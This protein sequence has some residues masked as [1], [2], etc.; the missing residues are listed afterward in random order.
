MPILPGPEW[1]EDS[2]TG[3]ANS[4]KVRARVAATFRSALTEFAP[5]LRC[6]YPGRQGVL[7]TD[8]ETYA[9]FLLLT[10]G[11]FLLRRNRLVRFDLGHMR[12][13]SRYIVT[14]RR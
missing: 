1:R 13:L 7:K 2:G 6:H 9:V 3:R 14:E 8:S 10:L 5:A 12:A 11:D 4:V